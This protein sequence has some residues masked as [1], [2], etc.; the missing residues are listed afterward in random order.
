MIKINSRR[1]E[2]LWIP[3]CY[4]SFLHCKKQNLLFSL[5]Q[6][7]DSFFSLCAIIIISSSSFGIPIDNEPP[8][9]QPEKKIAVSP[10]RSP[11]KSRKNLYS[12]GRKKVLSEVSRK[13]SLKSKHI[14]EYKFTYTRYCRSPLR[15]EYTFQQGVYVH[16]LFCKLFFFLLLFPL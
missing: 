5:I 3:D 12:P 10:E 2:V 1:R 13:I 6:K 4:V 16:D 9:N 7:F 15:T 11:R 14:R 8:Q